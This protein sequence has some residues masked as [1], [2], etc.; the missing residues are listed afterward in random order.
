MP[1][2]KGTGCD[3][4][5]APLGYQTRAA[6]NEPLTEADQLH[7][8]RQT[9]A[10]MIITGIKRTRIIREWPAERE[11]AHKDVDPPVLPAS[12]SLQKW[13]KFLSALS[14]NKDRR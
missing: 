2:R 3:L 5:G 10:A 9:G 1:A 7:V 12:T 11:L 4:R 8:A 14:A 13:Q 6:I